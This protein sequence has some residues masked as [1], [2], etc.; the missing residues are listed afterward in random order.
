V[1]GL[2]AKATRVVKNMRAF[3]AL[4]E[5]GSVGIH[6]RAIDV[7]VLKKRLIEAASDTQALLN[8]AL[9][10]RISVDRDTLG[11]HRWAEMKLDYDLLE[12][13]IGNLLDNAAKYSYPR[14]IIRVYGGTTAT[15]RPHISVASVGL[16]IRPDEIETVKQ[17]N[18]RGN[19]AALTTGEGSGIGLW[20]VDHLMRA[21]GG[22]LVVVPTDPNGLTDIKLVFPRRPA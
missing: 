11:G 16:K 18:R 2:G 13:A 21:Q 7:N 1:S 3:A 22:D 5:G 12:Q 9:N 14:T 20:I 4:A 8:P 19:E 10:I 15:G 6:L 17:R